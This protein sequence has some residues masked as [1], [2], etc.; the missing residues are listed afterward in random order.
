[1]FS[2]VFYYNIMNATSFKFYLIFAKL[3]DTLKYRA[4]KSKKLS[5]Y[6]YPFTLFFHYRNM[7]I[8]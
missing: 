3:P 5:K 7:D 6:S 8:V 1:M 4:G 2:R